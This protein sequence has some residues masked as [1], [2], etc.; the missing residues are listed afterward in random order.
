MLEMGTPDPNKSIACYISKLSN[1][2]LAENTCHTIFLNII[3]N[4]FNLRDTDEH[5][6]VIAC[7]LRFYIDNYD[8]QLH[9]QQYFSYIAV[10]SFIGGGNM[11]SRRKPSLPMI[12]SKMLRECG[13]QQ[14]HM[15]TLPINTRFVSCDHA[16]GEMYSI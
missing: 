8:V 14:L 12:N 11:R 13:D 16:H 9:F 3:H 10:V 2:F 15:Q 7:M 6:Y 5:E 4:T 1:F